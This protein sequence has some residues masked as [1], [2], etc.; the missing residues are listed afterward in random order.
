M[1]RTEFLLAYSN[2]LK[3]LNDIKGFEMERKFIEVFF[4]AVVEYSEKQREELNSVKLNNI[5]LRV[6]GKMLEQTA[7]KLLKRGT[8]KELMKMYLEI[9]NDFEHANKQQQW[10]GADDEAR[11]A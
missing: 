8:N 5:L 7:D 10:H 6:E 1:K 4:E 3:A 11:K 9:L 2:A